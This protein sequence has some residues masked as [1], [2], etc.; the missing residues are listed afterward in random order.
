MSTTRRS[1]GRRPILKT[2][3]RARAVADS[4]RTRTSDRVVVFKAPVVRIGC[5]IAP[6]RKAN[7]T[8]KGLTYEQ[9][10]AAVQAIDENVSEF[11]RAMRDAIVRTI[12]SPKISGRILPKPPLGIKLR[13]ATRAPNLGVVYD[14]EEIIF[15]LDGFLILA[16]A[17][18]TVCVESEGMLGV[19]DN[20]NYSKFWTRF[21]LCG[22]SKDSDNV[23]VTAQELAAFD[24]HCRGIGEETFKLLESPYETVIRKVTR[25]LNAKIDFREKFVAVAAEADKDDFHLLYS[26]VDRHTPFRELAEHNETAQQLQVLAEHYFADPTSKNAMIPGIDKSVKLISYE[27]TALYRGLFLRKL[28]PTMVTYIGVGREPRGADQLRGAHEYSKTPANVVTAGLIGAV[29]SRF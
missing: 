6:S 12:K 29:A 2:K 17:C 16:R 1:R 9:G 18:V 14:F 4:E 28:E 26:A 11:N 3:S 21:I 27:N 24:R 19:A 5:L 13:P 10:E 23:S 20:K 22:R 7:Q 15:E 25:Q 8:P